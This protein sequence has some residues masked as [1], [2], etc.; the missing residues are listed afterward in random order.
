MRHLPHR[1]T[2]TCRRAVDMITEYLDA[3]LPPAKMRWLDD[4]F[5]TC[6]DCAEYLAQL[7]ATI[8]ATGRIEPDR[9][10]PKTRDALIDLYRRT[11]D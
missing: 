7:R 9:L 3:A 11:H 6:V 2:V 5:A 1:R 4:H 8:A 10:A